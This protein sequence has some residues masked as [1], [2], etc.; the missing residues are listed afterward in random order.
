MSIWP[1]NIWRSAW[2]R[3]KSTKREQHRCDE[4]AETPGGRTSLQP[5]LYYRN[6]GGDNS[7]RKESKAPA[8]MTVL[9]IKAAGIWVFIV[10]LA[11][12]NGILRE[13]L[14]SP[15]LGETPALALSGI[16]LSALIFAAT[17]L[18]LPI[19]GRHEPSRYWSIGFL[20]LALTVLFEFLFGHYVLGNS[21]KNIAAAYNVFSGNLWAVVL[22]ATVVSPYL[23]ARLRGFF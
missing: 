4:F 15:L 3:W 16:M 22:L 2:S 1:E 23:A 19:L 10:F 17:L 21:W 5:P 14:W 18:L 13:K 11:I 12:L 7:N 6:R 20:W 8:I 9:L